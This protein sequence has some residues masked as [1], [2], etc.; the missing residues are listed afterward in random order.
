MKEGCEHFVTC[1]DSYFMPQGLALYE[2]LLKHNKGSI[3]W[4]ICLDKK[5]FEY[6]QKSAYPML[7]I[8][9]IEDLENEKL[10]SVKSTRTK[11]E[12]IWT[13]S[14]FIPGWVFDNDPEIPRVTYLDADMCFLSDSSVIYH[15]FEKSGKEVLI[16]EHAFDKEYEQSSLLG[17]FCV[18][19]I[20]YN[21][22]GSEEIRKW[23]EDRCL[24]WCY[25]RWEDGKFG[26]QKYLDQW[27]ILFPEKVHVLQSR[28]YILAPWNAS[29]YKPNGQILWH[30]HGL[31]LLTEGRVL[32]HSRYKI[33]DEIDRDIYYPYLKMLSKWMNDETYSSTR[34]LNYNQFK[35]TLIFIFSA[36]FR[37]FAKRKIYTLIPR[38]KVVKNDK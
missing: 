10:L 20:V 21:R 16:T 12:Y 6:L 9:F 13:L 38:I 5:S 23:W 22:I 8:L 18:Q 30:F 26:D 33:S 35:E 24:E 28:D 27:P 2:S 31:R 29:R 17:K 4:V 14:P 15:E 36:V 25:N 1:F 32:L 11:A 37:T 34:S 3:L 7:R 19:F